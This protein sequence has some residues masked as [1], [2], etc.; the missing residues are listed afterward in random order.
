MAKTATKLGDFIFP[1]LG[2]I[3]QLQVRLSN[4]YA[5]WKGV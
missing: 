5:S 1:P 4:A 2:R 3:A